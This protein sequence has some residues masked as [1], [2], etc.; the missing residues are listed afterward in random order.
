[1]SLESIRRRSDRFLPGGLGADLGALDLR[2]IASREGSDAATGRRPPTRGGR[3]G[4]TT[5]GALGAFGAFG[6]F[7]ER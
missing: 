5:L 3:A 4:G 1:M 2:T 7:R 6:A